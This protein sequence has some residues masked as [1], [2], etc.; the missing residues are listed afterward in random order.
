MCHMVA[1]SIEELH[2]MADQIGINRKWFQ[3]KNK[4]HPHYDISKSKR[5]LAV[6]H[7]A[8]E[9]DEFEILKVLRRTV[10]YPCSNCRGG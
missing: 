5:G 10:S 4:R 1:D 3:N 8:I 6:R 7:G 9:T 2:E